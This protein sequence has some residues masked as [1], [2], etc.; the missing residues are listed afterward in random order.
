MKNEFFTKIQNAEDRNYTKDS[1]QLRNLNEIYLTGDFLCLWSNLK[2]VLYFELQ[3][4]QQTLTAKN[5]N[6]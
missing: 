1:H 6:E 3:M 2:G 5:Y 4:P